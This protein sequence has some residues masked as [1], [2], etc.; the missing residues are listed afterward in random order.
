MENCGFRGNLRLGH[1]LRFVR[2]TAYHPHN[3]V[4]LAAVIPVE[5]N[6][7]SGTGFLL[8]YWQAKVAFRACE[9]FIFRFTG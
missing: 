5:R 7:E 3:S 8:L 2:Y 4:Y 1:L 6:L 9:Y